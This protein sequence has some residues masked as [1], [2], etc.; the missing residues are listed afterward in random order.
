MDTS[1]FSELNWLAILVSTLA[2]FAAGS[3]W[4][5]KLLFVKP[6]MRHIK[7]DP[8]APGARDGLGLIL[9]TAIVLSFVL[10]FG[11]AILREKIGITG[12][13]SGL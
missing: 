7:V 4:Y 6:W 10:S 13:L 11:M 2:V 12:A 9:I 1:I 8:N 3:L 5:S